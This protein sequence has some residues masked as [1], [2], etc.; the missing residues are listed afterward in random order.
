MEVD[1]NKEQGVSKEKVEGHQIPLETKKK[2]SQGFLNEKKGNFA[3]L[4]GGIVRTLKKKVQI[5]K[6][7][8]L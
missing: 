7:W 6:C 3:Q 1:G 4:A 2:L 8:K 5:M